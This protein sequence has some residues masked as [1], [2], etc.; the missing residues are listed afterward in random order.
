LSEGNEEKHEKPVRIVG[1]PAE[2]RTVRLPNTSQLT[3]TSP[4]ILHGALQIFIVLVLK[5]NLMVNFKASHDIISFPC[6]GYAFLD[7]CKDHI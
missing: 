4:I 3:S 7:L 2:I 1:F 5:I 6:F